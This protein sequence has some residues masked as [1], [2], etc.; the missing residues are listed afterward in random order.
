MIFTATVAASVCALKTFDDM[1][2][3][4]RL[5]WL[6]WSRNCP[7]LGLAYEASLPLYV[8]L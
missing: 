5:H 2:L 3:A 6:P 8:Y 7:I 1:V 4:V